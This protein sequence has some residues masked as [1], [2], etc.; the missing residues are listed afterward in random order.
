MKLGWPY[1]TLKNNGG[2][3]EFEWQGAGVMEFHID[4]CVSAALR[5]QGHDRAVQLVF[6]FNIAEPNASDLVETRIDVPAQNV[7]ET[8]RFLAVL[9]RDHKVPDRS[10]VETDD[11]GLERVPN[12]DGWLVSDAGPASEELFREVLARANE[13]S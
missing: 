3:L 10:H 11:S 7:R 12:S 4:R 13:S 8:E 2:Q 9:R 1:F 6:Q 5:P